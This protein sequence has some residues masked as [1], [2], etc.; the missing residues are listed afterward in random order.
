MREG[1]ERWSREKS[2]NMIVLK[3]SQFFTPFPLPSHPQKPVPL[4]GPLLIEMTSYLSM[5]KASAQTF[6]P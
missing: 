5:Y 2:K 1:R 6:T 4:L 3:H